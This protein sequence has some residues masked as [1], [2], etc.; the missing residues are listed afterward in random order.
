MWGSSS[1]WRS[2]VEGAAGVEGGGG[3]WGMRACSCSEVR[4]WEGGQRT[5]GWTSNAWPST[6]DGP[7]RTY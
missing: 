6:E 7:G 4:E 3:C 2:E 5:L 1:V